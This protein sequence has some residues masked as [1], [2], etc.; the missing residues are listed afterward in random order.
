MVTVLDFSGALVGWGKVLL[1]VLEISMH[2]TKESQLSLSVTCANLGASTCL[3]VDK[4]KFSAKSFASLFMEC[5]A[6]CSA[7]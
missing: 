4:S 5:S 7:F 2:N 3:L 6:S 1:E